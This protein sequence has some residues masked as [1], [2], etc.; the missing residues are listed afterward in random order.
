M[1][2]RSRLDTKTAIIRSSEMAP[3]PTQTARVDE[4][5]GMTMAAQLML[6]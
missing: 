4:V 3:T 5:K 1:L 6:T 2:A